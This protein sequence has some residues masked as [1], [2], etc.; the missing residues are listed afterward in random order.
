[1]EK[2]PICLPNFDNNIFNSAI[3]QIMMYNIFSMFNLSC[4][5]TYIKRNIL[6]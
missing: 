2:S 1:M 5:F 6:N 4:G 3:Q